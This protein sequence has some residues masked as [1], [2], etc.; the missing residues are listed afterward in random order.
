MPMTIAAEQRGDPPVTILTLVGELDASNFEGLIATV[1][2]AYEAGCRGLVL[3]LSGL[4]F[5]AS[6]GLVALYASE[7]IFR[8]QPA[9]DLDAGWQVFHDMDAEAGQVTNLRLVGTQDAV[10]RVLDRTGLSRLFATDSSVD[11]AIAAIEGG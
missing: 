4:T 1:Q 5:M 9:P 7:R 3:D 11:A 10:Q 6:S 2:D 8:G